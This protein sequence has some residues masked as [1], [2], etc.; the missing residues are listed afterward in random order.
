MPGR[1]PLWGHLI[2]S[3]STAV[4]A[5]TGVVASSPSTVVMIMAAEDAAPVDFYITAATLNFSVRSWYK[6]DQGRYM[7]AQ[8]LQLAS[9]K[10][11]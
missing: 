11:A 1:Q 10:A 6:M 9:R 8:Q 3:C 7:Q 2:V 4:T 5:R